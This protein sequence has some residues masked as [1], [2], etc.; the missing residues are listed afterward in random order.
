MW[1]THYHKKEAYN[2]VKKHPTKYQ[3]KNPSSPY[4]PTAGHSFVF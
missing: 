4:L 3:E 2:F 1:R